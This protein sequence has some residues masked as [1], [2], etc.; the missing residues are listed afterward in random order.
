MA[1]SLESQCAPEERACSAHMTPI[2]TLFDS[3]ADEIGRPRESMKVYTESLQGVGLTSVHQLE[4]FSAEEWDSLPIPKMYIRRLRHALETSTEIDAQPLLALPGKQYNFDFQ[5][6]DFLVAGCPLYIHEVANSGRGTG[7]NIWDCSILLSFYLQQNIDIVAGRR[8]IELGA[9]TGLTGLSAALLGA[10]VTLTDLPDVITNLQENI[11][12]NQE[13]IQQKLG[14]VEA[15]AL[16]WFVALQ[17]GVDG[18]DKRLQEPFDVALAADVIW[19]EELIEPFVATLAA[20][21]KV[22]P[23][24]VSFIAHQTR[25]TRA[26]TKLF[27]QMKDKGLVVE[28]VTISPNVRQHLDDRFSIF[29]VTVK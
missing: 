9:G 10:N 27:N 1:S 18:L 17:R 26:D 25:S 5:A 24:M 15:V 22:N 19:V 21:S 13:C 12:L 23:N 4:A 28:G 14:T 6:S 2:S 7:F 20:L 16:D 8:V 29:K 3:V 11:K